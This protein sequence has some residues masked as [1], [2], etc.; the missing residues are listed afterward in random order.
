MGWLT[1]TLWQKW[2]GSILEI[3]YEKNSQQEGLLPKELIT[4]RKI[5]FSKQLTYKIYH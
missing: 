1:H 5:S 3:K 4:K 2:G